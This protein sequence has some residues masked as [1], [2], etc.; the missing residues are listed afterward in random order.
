MLQY[1]GHM[2]QVEH[3]RTVQQ[4]NICINITAACLNTYCNYMY[5]TCNLNFTFQGTQISLTVLFLNNKTQFSEIHEQP[6][7][8]VQFLFF[9][10]IYSD[11]WTGTVPLNCIQ[12]I[13]YTDSWH[14]GNKVVP[15]RL[16]TI[17]MN[18][19]HNTET[20]AV[21]C[22]N[23]NFLASRCWNVHFLKNSSVSHNPHHCRFS[24]VA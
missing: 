20:V 22:S 5:C 23:F 24:F 2:V 7:L 4:G 9:F 3:N 19:R 6:I 16:S 12:S 17:P 15:F 18:I 8:Y 1:Y 11:R 21:N 14:T 10:K 13:L